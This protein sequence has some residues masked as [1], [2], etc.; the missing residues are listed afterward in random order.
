MQSP[1]FWRGLCVSQAHPD[2]IMTTI[3]STTTAE[4]VKLAP[5]L[6][7]H[8]DS[9]RRRIIG[10]GVLVVA[11]LLF[12]R[13]AL[14]GFPIQV[15][16]PWSASVL[17]DGGARIL[18]GQAP[19]GDF[20]TPIGFSYLGLVAIA[21]RLEG[22]S[23]HA[24]AWLLAAMGFAATTAGWFLASRRFAPVVAA[25]V[26]LAT[27][28]TA[29]TVA[30]FEL[31]RPTAALGGH[32]TRWCWALLLLVVTTVLAP[33]RREGGR[34]VKAIEAALIGV[35]LTLMATG[36][37]TFA[38]VAAIALIAGWWQRTWRPGVAEAAI[39]ATSAALSLA[40]AVVGTGASVTGY[41]DDL[42]GLE[43]VSLASL[44]LQYRRLFD[45]LL[46]AL[47]LAVAC[48][49]W[50]ERSPGFSPSLR[51]P[52]PHPIVAAGLIS[53]LCFALS[54]SN[55]IEHVSPAPLV[56]LVVLAGGT[57]VVPRAASVIAVAVLLG[58]CARF[59]PAVL[60]GPYATSQHG[61]GRI[62]RGAY[63]GLAF[64]PAGD[65]ARTRG[66]L[67]TYLSREPKV[68]VAN[69]WYL[70][71][72]DGIELL[73]RHAQGSP[74]VA[75]MDFINPFP[76]ALGWPELR[77]DHLFW[78]FGRNVGKRNAPSPDALLGD[79]DLVLVPKVPLFR[80]TLAVKMDIYGAALR[81][82]FEEVEQTEWWRLLRRRAR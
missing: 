53:A 43:Q 41:L 50:R 61:A 28:V 82:R 76:Y 26:A 79:A 57:L 6:D 67:Q 20:H 42:R 66:D 19:H 12:T 74:R 46:P 39:V 64:V 60:F 68:L 23:P 34:G 17:L 63:R 33:P 37:A 47:A 24:L 27:G 18:A 54:A 62:E 81:E 40:L 7:Q 9:R 31:S 44:L 65:V 4:A 25:A 45:P 70:Y 30:Y 55:G 51:E 21:M 58:W 8:D 72:N 69:G 16:Y 32:Y 48:I 10:T 35:C 13:L 3:P 5:L 11:A 77:N 49:R 78:H 38:I 56:A 36:K 75:S 1:R 22:G 59:T 80:E 14:G 29:G 15:D 52:L 71:L 73:S 2:G